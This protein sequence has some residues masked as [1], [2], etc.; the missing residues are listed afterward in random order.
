MFD[1]ASK[2]R[3]RSSAAANHRPHSRAASFGRPAA[4][5]NQ[6]LQHHLRSQSLRAKLAVGGLHDPQEAEADRTADSIVSGRAGPCACGGTCASCRSDENKIRRKPTEA[7]NSQVPSAR[8]DAFGSSAG[9]PL[10]AGTRSFFEPH[11]GDLSGVRIHDTEEAATTA[12]AIGARAYTVGSDIGFAPGAYAPG[13]SDG[14][15]LLA[16]ELAHVAQDGAVVRRQPRGTNLPPPIVGAPQPTSL[17]LDPSQM[18]GPSGCFTDADIEALDK[19][20]EDPWA[21]MAPQ[22]APTSKQPQG[23]D[24]DSEDLTSGRTVNIGPFAAV[25]N[26]AKGPNPV[27]TPA[28]VPT[29]VSRIVQGSSNRTVVSGTSSMA[30]RTGHQPTTF[31]QGTLAGADEVSVI[32]HGSAVHARI[33]TAAYSARQLA[34]ELVASGWTGGTVRLIICKTGLCGAA[35][36]TFGQELANE[37]AALGAE[38]AVIAPAG[39]ANIGAGIPGLP[40]VRTPGAP[41]LSPRG[42]DWEIYVA[43]PPK[44]PPFF[45]LKAWKGTGVGALKTGALIALSILHGKAV[46][47]RMQKQVQETG[48]APVGPTGNTLYD[49]GAWFLDP[50]NEAGRSVPFSQRFHMASWRQ[51]IRDAADKKAVGDTYKMP[52][53][54]D[55]GWDALRE[56]RKTK[57]CYVYYRKGP[58]GYWYTIKGSCNEDEFFPPDL[59]KVIDPNVSDEELRQYLELPAPEPLSPEGEPLA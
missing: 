36:T 59:N 9:H 7:K 1:V 31:G 43:Q 16:H 37:L 17:M 15:R 56:H 12:A 45:S 48:F 24:E 53:E 20:P 28:P 5:S 35:P 54:T 22:A 30:A 11:F 50:T 34:E 13:S 33:G 19:V 58:N 29:N 8:A 27:P 47:E 32:A 10:D 18:C 4:I 38:S 26:T 25:A 51:T 55:D 39:N 49:L 6:L 44:E 14:K 42:W 2:A 52:W 41:S 46:I 21:A 40:Q 3:R 23:Q 57:T